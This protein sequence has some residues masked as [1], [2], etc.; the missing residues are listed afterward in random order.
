[1]YVTDL[2]G[3][4]DRDTIKVS[5]NPKPLVSFTATSVCQGFT[6]TFNNTSSDTSGGAFTS[7]WAFNDAAAGT[8]NVASPTYNYASCGNYSVTLVV[9]S[10]SGCIDLKTNNVIV[11][12][13]PNAAFTTTNVCYPAASPFN[14]SSTVGGTA[15]LNS[16]WDFVYLP[17]VIDSMS[18]VASPNYYY[19]ADGTYNVALISY[20]AFCSDTAYGSVTVYPKPTADFSTNNVCL[21]NTTLFTD[22]SNVNAPDSITNWQWDYDFVAPFSPNYTASVGTGSINIYPTIN[23]VNAE[24]IITT[25]NGCKDTIFKPVT[26]YPLP[27]A[28]FTV[29]PVC[30]NSPSLFVNNSTVSSGSIDFNNWIFDTATGTPVSGV[31]S[32]ANIYPTSNTYSVQL[33]VT[34]NN[35]CVDSIIV[36][37]DVYPNPTVDFTTDVYRGCEPLCVNLAELATISAVP[38][39]SANATYAWSFGDSIMGSS[40]NEGHCY[41]NDGLYDVTLAVTSNNGC[42][43]TLVKPA[44]IT[45]YPNPTAQF[46]ADPM[47]TTILNPYITFMDASS[48]GSYLNWNFGDS[49]AIAVSNITDNLLHTYADTGTYTVT[50]IVTTEYNCVDSIQ[51]TIIVGPEFIFYAPNAFTPNKDGLND[52][53]YGTGIGVK[54]YEL[55]IYNRWGNK[56]ATVNKLSGGWDG[57]K[58]NGDLCPSEVYIWQAKILDVLDKD[59]TYNGTV[60]LIK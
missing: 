24:L 49:S 25:N 21:N 10:D 60:T 4:K 30:L 29:A 28:T 9:T 8:S 1:M 46:T 20:T 56:I 14:N 5:V 38:P 19:P 41:E 18:A 52:L 57:T 16:K 12:C 54:E 34:T 6:T 53:F 13:V 17:A 55:T 23:A 40:P 32:P 44:Y 35:G 22:L 48:G 3:C 45:V 51:H 59:H 58:S 43:T 33:H 37:T 42:I 15:T 50:Q 27:V 47:K 7:F 31:A 39:G 2:H 11:N 36:N 26:I